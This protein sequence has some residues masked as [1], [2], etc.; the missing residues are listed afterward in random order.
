MLHVPDPNAAAKVPLHI[1]KDT[2]GER[3]MK[4]GIESLDELQI[5]ESLDNL[6]MLLANMNNK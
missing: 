2:S 5:Q 3:L 1:K 6:D 4:P